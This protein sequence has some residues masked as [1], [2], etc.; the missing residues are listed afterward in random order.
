[1]QHQLAGRKAFLQR[2]NARCCRP[3]LRVVLRV[4]GFAAS[5]KAC[6]GVP[7]S[8]SPLLRFC[9]CGSGSSSRVTAL[10]ACRNKL[11]LTLPVIVPFLLRPAKS[12]FA[13]LV[14]ISLLFALAL[15]VGFGAVDLRFGGRI[16]AKR[17]CKPDIFLLL[18][19]LAVIC[20]CQSNAA[21]LAA[22][23]AATSRAWRVSTLPAACASSRC[24][25]AV[26]FGAAIK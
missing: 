3:C 9:C 18:R 14:L 21:S 23:S 24:C 7:L 19:A 22:L 11:L 12:V 16:E 17:F 4:S 1:M 15:P 6:G 20:S 8:F 13:G 2:G 10:A 5:L 25:C 26:C